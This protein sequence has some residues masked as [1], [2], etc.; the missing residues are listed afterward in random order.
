MGEIPFSPVHKARKLDVSRSRTWFGM[1]LH[2]NF[3]AV[4]GAVS[5]KSSKMTLKHDEVQLRLIKTRVSKNIPSD[6]CPVDGEVE[7]NA[8]SYHGRSRQASSCNL[9]VY[10]RQ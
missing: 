1:N 9:T 7:I 5:L 2:T 6:R 8:G 10:Q 4:L 3:S